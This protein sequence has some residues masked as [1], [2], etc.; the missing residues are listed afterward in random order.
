MSEES[1]DGGSERR[2]SSR[3]M[4]N[5]EFAELDGMLSEYVA[6]ISRGGI[7][8]R[9]DVSLPSGTEVALNFTVLLD[10]MESIEGSGVVVRT[11]EHPN[12]GLGIEFVELTDRSREVV[13]AICRRQEAMAAADGSEDS[14]G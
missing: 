1:G 7:F 11:G 3:I 13:E 14:G 2:Q 4:V 8:L 9:C 12:P 6:N 10:D 5:D